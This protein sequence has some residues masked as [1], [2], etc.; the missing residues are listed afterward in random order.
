[1]IKCI[2]A[3]ILIALLGANTQ[4]VELDL[5][6]GYT[7]TKKPPSG[8]WYQKEFDHT[9]KNNDVNYQI[10]LRFNPWDNIYFT[11][12]YKYLGEFTVSADF[13]AVDRVYHNWQNGG[14]APP[15]S[16]LTGKGKIQ[17]LYAKGEYHFSS[18]LFLTWGG[19]AHKAE[20]SVSSPKEYRVIRYGDYKGEIA[21]PISKQHDANVG[22][23]WTWIYGIG[24]KYKQ[25]SL[26]AEI[27]DIERSGDYPTI[28]QGEA[29]VITLLYTF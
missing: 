2:A 23:R 17:G 19:W 22:V 3:L 11:T 14:K 8:L 6:L 9:L 29:E 25:W 28:Y 13:I 15:L 5:G 4:A 1:M 10:G 16:H 21:E 26:L 24:Y 7:W 18:G 20:W 27:W 12:G